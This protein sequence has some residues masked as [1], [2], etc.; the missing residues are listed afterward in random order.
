MDQG[1]LQQGLRFYGCPFFGESRQ[2][3]LGELVSTIFEQ[4]F[5]RYL[6]CMP[7]ILPYADEAFEREMI[8]LGLQ[9]WIGYFAQR[10]L[11]TYVSLELRESAQA[12]TNLRN[13]MYP[14]RQKR[15]FR[16]PWI[17]DNYPFLIADATWNVIDANRS[18]DFLRMAQKAGHGRSGNHFL[19]SNQPALCAR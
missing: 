6:A 12:V 3:R 10:S 18:T 5:A 11:E 13:R 19:S 4:P 9:N 14:H 7:L 8:A 2:M 16:F 17:T 1:V 15:V